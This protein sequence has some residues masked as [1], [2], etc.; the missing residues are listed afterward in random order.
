MPSALTLAAF[1][2]EIFTTAGKAFST[3]GAKLVSSEPGVTTDGAAAD[4]GCAAQPPEPITAPTPAAARQNTKILLSFQKVSN[5]I[6]WIVTPVS[7]YSDDPAQISS[8]DK[9]ESTHRYGHG[10]QHAQISSPHRDLRSL[11]GLARLRCAD[12]QPVGFA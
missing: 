6:G 3:T 5:F 12:S 1:D 10:R 7:S 8:R 9:L 11:S 2:E 4:T